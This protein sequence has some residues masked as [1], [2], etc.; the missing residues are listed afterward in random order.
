[1]RLSN[2]IVCFMISGKAGVGK[3]TSALVIDILLRKLGYE[4]V[5]QSFASHLKKVAMEIGWN[6]NKDVR[7]RRLLQELGA[8]ARTYDEDIW[9]R[10]LFENF[11]TS[12]IFYP[13]AIT[14]DDW[15]F[16]NEL[17]YVTKNQDP[18]FKPIT[19][20]IDAP[21][22]ET[23]RGTA[24]ELDVS[25][26]SLPLNNNNFS[27]YDYI[28]DN[29]GSMTQLEYRLQIMIDEVIKNGTKN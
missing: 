9:A 5:L 2:K 17:L 3:T 14:I 21:W 8:V 22:R 6:G 23:L 18:M 10:V 4:L 11:I 15:R 24:Q 16:Q 20:R 1:M 13:D 28:I 7:G 19:V 26:T 25:E 12:R 27:Y 29:T